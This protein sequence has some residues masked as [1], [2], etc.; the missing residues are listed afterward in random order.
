MRIELSL[1]AVVLVLTAGCDGDLLGGPTPPGDDDAGGPD[2]EVDAEVGMG[3]DDVTPAAMIFA[4]SCASSGACHVTGGQY[5]DLSREALAALPGAPSRGMPGET[6]VVPGDPEASWLYRKVTG[7]QGAGGG[8]LMPVGTSEPIDGVPVLEAWIRAGAPTRCDTEPPAPEIPRDPNTLPQA[9]L[10]TCGGP[11]AG[12]S[13]AR[14]RRVERA[15]WTHSAGRNLRDGAYSNPFYAP[16]GNY[17][18]YSAGVSIDP[19]TLDL[20]LLVLPQVSSLWSQR[21]VSPRLWAVYTEPSVRCMFNDAAPSDA[22]IDNYVDR[23]LTVG[24]L[25]RSP[26]DGERARLRALVVEGIAT[27]AGDLTQ[28]RMTLTHVTG[29]AWL[30]SGALFHSELGEP[31]E[32]DPTGRRRLTDDE[33]ALALGAVISTHPPGSSLPNTVT[34]RPGEPDRSMPEHGWLGQIRVAVED[35]TIQDPE[36]LRTL[37][38]TYRGG[39]DLSRAD[40]A[41]DS[42]SRD[43]PARGEHWLA[44]QIAGFF[45]E[46]LDYGSAN[47]AFKDSPVATSAWEDEGTAGNSWSNLQHSYYG[48]ESTFVAQLDDTIARAV[49]ESESSGAD[50]LRTLLTTRMWRLPSNLSMSNG[51]PCTSSTECPTGMRCQAAI[52]MCASSSSNSTVSS[53]RVYGLR[54]NVPTTSE[55]RWVMVPEGERAG[56]L[57]HPAWLIAHGGNFEDDA[58]AVLRGRWIREHLYCQT[59]PGLELVMVEAQLVP[60]EPALRARDRVRVSIEEG[61]ES[62]TCMG[63]HSLMNTLGMPFEIYNHAGFLREDDHGM[64]PDG[65]SVIDNGPDPS[66]EGEVTDAVELTQ[67]FADSPYARLCFIRHVFRYFMGR[68]ETMAD[69]CTLTAMASAFEGGSFFAM[70]EALVTSDTFLY[71]H[72]GGAR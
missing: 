29:A 35:G 63:C 17:S 19:A 31:V 28:R 44:P 62:A 58:S 23:L 1:M 55:G 53:H 25:F 15:G 68:D 26:T 72:V 51:T 18:T 38:R 16:E 4:T 52:G 27:E 66:L 21:D 64:S 13:P 5:P 59:V 70:L 41:L 24:I 40:I 37:L 57:T 69:A 22:C 65:H 2:V 67:M 11:T 30:T 42:D 14:I 36:V 9:E 47:S 60:S 12:S 43:L 54:E 46:W 45:R 48:Y 32:G 61:T 3:C 71:R 7:M 10:F 50:V 8:L 6:L 39:V 49:I 34:A 56:V 33:L 20:Y